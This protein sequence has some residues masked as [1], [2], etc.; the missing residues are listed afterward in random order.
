MFL[1]AHDRY[2]IILKVVELT[3]YLEGLEENDV[4]Q[5]GTYRGVK[6]FLT[7]KYFPGGLRRAA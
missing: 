4:A 3:F 2:N 1:A 7:L 5:E 6:S